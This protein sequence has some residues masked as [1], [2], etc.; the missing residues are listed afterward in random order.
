VPETAQ[1]RTSAPDRL[2]GRGQRARSLLVNPARDSA[3]PGA[4]P[5]RHIG[6]ASR[7][8]VAPPRFEARLVTRLRAVV[9]NPCCLTGCRA[10][11]RVDAPRLRVIDPHGPDVAGPERSQAGREGDLSPAAP[12]IAGDRRRE[13]NLEGDQSPGRRGRPPPA[14]AGVLQ[15]PVAEQG[16]EVG[17]CAGALA[18]GSPG[19]GIQAAGAGAQ[20]DIKRAAG[21]GDAARLRPG[22]LLRGVGIVRTARPYGLRRGE[23]ERGDANGSSDPVRAHGTGNAAN[24]RIG[25]GMQQAR[26]L[27]ACRTRGFGRVAARPWRRKPSRWCETT[28]AERDR[29]GWSLRR[30][31]RRSRG[32]ARAAAGVDARRHVDGGAAG[33]EP[34]ERWPDESQGRRS[35]TIRTEQGAL[36]RSRDHEGRPLML[37]GARRRGR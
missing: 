1:A 24:P 4:P 13:E 23:C 33:H 9:P 8:L 22:E 21:R 2:T 5:A 30:R 11:R 31:S 15:H 12:P 28:R 18:R 37:F 25:S 7:Q 14:T 10:A 6:A 20:R 35:E 16:L 3:E 36:N 29:R 34:R 27:R 32:D 26:D 17:P 19:N